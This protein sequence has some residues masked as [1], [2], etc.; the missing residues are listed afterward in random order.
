MSTADSIRAGGKKTLHT[1]INELGAMLRYWRSV[2]G[3]SQMTLSL[4]SGVSQRHLSFIESGRS[5][6]SR[7]IL[8]E[9]ASALEIPLRDRNTLLLA[10]GYAPIYA[11]D[12]WNSEEMGII[13]NALQRMLRLHE[14][15][16]AF[17]MDRYWNVLMMNDAAPRFFNCF[18]DVSALKTRN[19]LHM[20]CDPNGM[21]PSIVNWEETEKW[22][23]E[24]VY[25]ES[26]GRSLDEKMKELLAEL[27]A[28]SASHLVQSAPPKRRPTSDSTGRG[29]PKNM[30]VI[31]ITL[32]KGNTVLNYFSMVT[33]VG[34]PRAVAAQ[35]L[36]VDCMF[37]ADEATECAHAAFVER[38]SGRW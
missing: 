25:R 26:V 12:V 38:Y 2:S 9:V 21:R 34:V 15:F 33:T 19:L 37:P 8:V 1:K 4:D 32:K 29:A 24:R 18:I 7:E 3:K 22:L 6:P 5:V 27:R 28:Y 13:T 10:A 16:P 30:P 20:M 36:R 11:D 31:P 17:V 23:I 14:P 35:E